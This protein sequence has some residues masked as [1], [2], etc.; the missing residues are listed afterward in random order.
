MPY[1]SI[2]VPRGKE[3][4]APTLCRKPSSQTQAGVSSQQGAA[5]LAARSDGPRAKPAPRSRPDDPDRG[6]RLDRD[7]GGW[8]HWRLTAAEA[9]LHDA[10]AK[11]EV[12]R[13]GGCA[14]T[15]R[16]R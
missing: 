6:A 2:A 3:A 8:Q 16:P 11:R 5:P 13:A 14:A 15:A 12:C 4:I 7:R 1:G 10:D 9:I